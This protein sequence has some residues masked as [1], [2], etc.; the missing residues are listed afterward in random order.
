V[1]TIKK[2][3]LMTENIKVGMSAQYVSTEGRP[4]PAQVLATRDTISDNDTSPLPR[5][6]EGHIHVMVFGLKGIFGRLDIPLKE[7][8]EAIP[9]YTINGKLVGY[10]E[11]FN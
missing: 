3:T 9:D 5:P 10:V 4:Q 6:A 8:A 2:G 7:T 11:V 1:H